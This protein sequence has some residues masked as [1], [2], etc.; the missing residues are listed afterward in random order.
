MKRA[1][2]RAALL[3]ALAVALAACAAP[4]PTERPARRPI[5]GGAATP[6]AVS[7]ASLAPIGTEGVPIDLPSVLSLAGEK[8][9]AVRLARERLAAAEAR[10]TRSFAELLP[11]LVLAST[12]A[13]H[14][15]TIQ[16]THGVFADSV[17]QHEMLGGTSELVL[18]TN[19]VLAWLR[20][21]RRRDAA[22]EDVEAATQERIAAASSTYFD[23]V[24]A[25]AE[26]A[27]ARDAVAS[28]R[29]FLEIAASREKNATGLAV[30]RLRA[31]SEVAAAREGLILATERAR[32]VSIRLASILRLDPRVTLHAGEREVRPLT[33]VA[34]DAAPDELVATALANHPDV[35]AA[36]SRVA[37]ADLD[38]DAAHF[39]PFLPR[40][41][42]GVG[43]YNG[44]LGFDGPNLTH[45][46][47][48][49]DYYVAAELRLSGFGLGDLA[50]ARET[51]ARLRAEKVLEDD[52]RER[53]A[54]DV[55]EAL[56]VVRSRSAAID[57]A[58]DELRAAEEARRIARKRLEQGTGLAVDVITADEARTRAASHLVAAI[59]SYN[60]AQYRLLARLGERP[61]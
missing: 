5:E 20:D 50:H 40:L 43:G 42:A 10:A 6:G 45:L 59:T 47:D 16:D 48:R 55:L 8:P 29:A 18:D 33:L 11:S 35:R 4:P 21:R 30:D 58:G 39:G 34:P 3:G 32:I 44:G 26:V 15:G 2:R 56:E 12:F 14:E 7:S 23:L 57:V 49:E 53:V 41:R 51:G 22:S 19:G 13:R 38:D 36:R 9:N 60:A 52:A 31:E 37:A 61:G 24:A 28:A 54:A 27:I 17:W 1:A 46:R 25:E